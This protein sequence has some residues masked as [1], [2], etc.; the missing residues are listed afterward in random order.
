MKTFLQDI[1]ETVALKNEL[2]RP[3]GARL[4][5]GGH[6]RRAEGFGKTCYEVSF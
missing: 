5:K 4:T 3:P 2:V 6:R 1:Y